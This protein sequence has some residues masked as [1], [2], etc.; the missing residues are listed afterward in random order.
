[1]NVSRIVGPAIAGA[2]LASLGS[3]LVF[4]LNAVVSVAA[5]FTILRW[6]AERKE[7]ALPGER[8]V[9]AMRVGLQYVRQAPRLQITLLRIGLFML[10]VSGADV[11]AAAAGQA[12]C[13]RAAPAPSARCSAPP[14]LRRGGDGGCTWGACASA[15]AAIAR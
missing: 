7:S 1:M 15:S 10:Q 6:K 14:A 9:G 4:A 8:F 3:A 5:F 2:I 13:P 11:A 12:S